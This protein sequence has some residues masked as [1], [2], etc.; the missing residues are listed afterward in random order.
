MRKRAGVNT[1]EIHKETTCIGGD[2]FENFQRKQF[3]GTGI[4]GNFAVHF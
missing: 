3:V 2:L 4:D 1:A